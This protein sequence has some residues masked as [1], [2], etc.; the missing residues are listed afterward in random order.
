M[1]DAQ[2]GK[3]K[4][5]WSAWEQSGRRLALTN[6]WPAF[7]GHHGGE[8]G[9]VLLFEI[10][11]PELFKVQFLS[12]ARNKGSHLHEVV[13]TTSNQHYSGLRMQIWG[14]NVL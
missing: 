5:D 3:W 9:D 2:G 4:T 14:C 6:G 8:I 7:V 12:V 13:V 10:M 11:S 1:Q